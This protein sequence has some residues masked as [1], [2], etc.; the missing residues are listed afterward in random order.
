MLQAAAEHPHF[1]AR[2]Q[3]NGNDFIL[4]QGT[5]QRR[6][7]LLGYAGAGEAFRPSRH[8]LPESRRPLREGNGAHRLTALGRLAEQGS[9]RFSQPTTRAIS[10]HLSLTSE[11]STWM[12]VLAP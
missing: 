4:G 9:A 2:E 3:A 12:I 11:P 8:D 6:Q 10:F 7:G 5:L 1:L